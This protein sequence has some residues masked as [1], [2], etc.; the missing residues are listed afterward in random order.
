MKIVRTNNTSAAPE[1]SSIKIKRN[2]QRYKLIFIRLNLSQICWIRSLDI[3]SNSTKLQ[4]LLCLSV[5]GQNL[6]QK[7]AA[8][9]V[10]RVSERAA[11]H[12][13][14]ESH[15]STPTSCQNPDIKNRQ[16]GGIHFHLV[17]SPNKPAS[18]SESVFSDGWKMWVKVGD[19]IVFPQTM[20]N[21]LTALVERYTNKWNWRKIL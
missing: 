16:V 12:T 13:Q 17:C 2:N 3:L 10:T 8:E 14:S 20:K 15:Q 7:C 4:W 5:R 11:L 9:T 6:T 21:H 19:L 18:S 1:K